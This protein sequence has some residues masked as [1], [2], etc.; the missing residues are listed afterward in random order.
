M[1]A[2]TTCPALV[3]P[4]ALSTGTDSPVSDDSSTSSSRR[5]PHPPVRRDHVALRQHHEIAHD[6]VGRRNATGRRPPRTTA[7]E[8][9]LIAD[10]AVTARSARTSWATPTEVFTTITKAMTTVSE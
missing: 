7:A 6:Q 10:R 8:G 5:L 4:A 1:P 3:A 2:D 9:A